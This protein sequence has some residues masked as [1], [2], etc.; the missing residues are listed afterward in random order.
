MNNLIEE[1]Q[2]LR[3][4]LIYKQEMFKKVKKAIKAERNAPYYQQRDLYDFRHALMLLHG[5]YSNDYDREVVKDIRLEEATDWNNNKKYANFYHIHTFNYCKYE[6]PSW[7]YLSAVMYKNSGFICYK[8]D[9]FNVVKRRMKDFWLFYIK[10]YRY[11]GSLEEFSILC[12]DANFNLYNMFKEY[13]SKEGTIMIM[14]Y[15]SLKLK[16]IVIY[17]DKNKSSCKYE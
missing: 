9:L 1:I 5:Q 3:A 16:D 14:N 6:K 8:K 2:A 10:E 12:N 13:V 15:P 7:V 17:M 4:E 11:E